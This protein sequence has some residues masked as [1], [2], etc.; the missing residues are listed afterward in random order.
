MTDGFGLDHLP[1]G[2]VRARDGGDAHVAVRVGDDVLDLR[3]VDLPAPRE[4]FAQ[5]SLNDFMALGPGV[6]RDTRAA[7][8][9]A[10]ESGASLLPLDHLESLLPVAVGDYVDFYSSIHHA[11][12]LGRIFRPDAEPLLPNWLHLPVGYH[13]RAGT[14]GV[15]GTPVRRPHGM[16]PD[17]DGVPRLMPTRAL[18]IE[19]ELG[20]IVGVGS[21][22]PVA[23]DHAAEHVFGV[24]LVNDWSARDIQAFEYQPLGPFLGKSFATTTAAW[25]TPLEA[26]LRVDPPP[27]D[28]V[29]DPYLRAAR[30]WGIDI[31]LSVDLN[32]EQI[33]ATNFREMYWTFAQQLAHMT[34]NGATTRTGD[35]FASGTVSGPGER[36]R[37]SLIEITWRGR[38]PLVLRDGTT[39]TFLNDGDQV[40]LR[41]RAGAITLGECAGVI[42]PA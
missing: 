34:I 12:N 35:L 36:E 9:S 25:V 21:D 27:Q 3:Q 5:G 8:R 26:L 1:Y 28:P 42:V 14:L 20:F 41:G 39:R 2:V 37:G 33:A 18:D 19:L 31:D 22:T 17:E 4:V 40:T 38:D 23:P 29:P 30:P 10:I 6:W 32:G 15:S 24:V 16:V 13:G 11:T 7:I